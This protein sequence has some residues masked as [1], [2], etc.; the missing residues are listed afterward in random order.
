MT[1]KNLFKKIAL[2][3]LVI[4]IFQCSFGQKNYLP[5]YVIQLNGD[6]LHGFI[7][8]RKWDKNPDKIAFRKE[9]SDN[10][11][12]YTPIGI[13]GFG[14][15]DVIYESAIIETEISSDNPIDFSSQAEFSMRTD[16]TF[17][18]T[19]IRG[20]KCLYFYKNN[21]GKE[22]FYIR[23][24]LS[25]EFLKYK[26]YIKRGEI[27]GSNT[28]TENKRYLGQLSIYL[29]D[30]QLIQSKLNDTKYGKKSMENLF[31]SY[32]KCT[33]SEIVYQK[34]TEKLPLEFGI[35]AGLSSTSIKFASSL[36]SYSYLVL[37][38]FKPSLNFTTGL[39]FDVG[40]PFNQGK[41]SVYNEV[42]YTSYKFNGR[43]Q[44]N[45]NPDIHSIYNTTIGLSNIK[46]NEMLRFKYPVGSAFVF[47]NAGMTLGF[48]VSETNYRKEDRKF[49]ST[50]TSDEGRAFAFN[51]REEG[52]LL[53]LGTKFKKVSFEIRFERGD[54][55]ARLMYLKSDENKYFF[56]LG[57]KF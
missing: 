29:N 53:G 7:D 26:K 31:V 46:V 24:G 5:G 15:K 39:F 42:I 33:N 32:Y 45:L 54:G 1:T 48:G 3:V 43:F 35:L 13:K 4:L 37:T 34:K 47:L 44:D 30:C 23:N 16:T 38:D 21:Y 27:Q 51:G 28:L 6:T 20:V 40:L 52:Y 12:H 25:Y 56:L 22:Q 57:Y 49:Y 55:M 11:S 9:M 41:W 10:S 50:E 19:M 17:L 8:Y 36:D 2:S 14:V 18:Q